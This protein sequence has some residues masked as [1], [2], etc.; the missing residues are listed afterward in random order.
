M[1]PRD[2]IQKRHEVESWTGAIDGCRYDARRN[3]LTVVEAEPCSRHL[4][5]KPV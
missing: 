4:R 2:L 1:Q 3:L 5:V